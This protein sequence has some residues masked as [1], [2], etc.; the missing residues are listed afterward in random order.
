[1]STDSLSSYLLL[2]GPWGL[3]E[4]KHRST[5]EFKL[6]GLCSPGLLGAWELVGRKQLCGA[7]SPQ[8]RLGQLSDWWEG[9]EASRI[10]SGENPSLSLASSLTPFPEQIQN[11]Y[12]QQHAMWNSVIHRWHHAMASN[13]QNCRCLAYL[14]ATHIFSSALC[15]SSY[16]LLMHLKNCD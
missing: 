1:M 12:Q 8:E 3:R 13:P 6:T 10:Y 9:M 15:L 11:K 16:M 14:K 4:D 2:P 5:G 7:H